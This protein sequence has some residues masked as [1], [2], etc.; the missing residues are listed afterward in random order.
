MNRR[1]AATALSLLSLFALHKKLRKRKGI[2]RIRK[3]RRQRG[4]FYTLWPELKRDPAEFKKFVRMSLPAF[5][6]LL[7]L[8]KGRFGKFCF[9]L[10]KP[11]V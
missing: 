9:F 1:L 10:K 5:E 6:K 2:H 3:M 7:N 8:V 11:C 4:A